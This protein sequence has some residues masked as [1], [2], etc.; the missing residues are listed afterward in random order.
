MKYETERF[1]RIV[2]KK[3][4][5]CKFMVKFCRGKKCGKFG[6][7]NCKCCSN[8]VYGCQKYIVECNLY[9]ILYFGICSIWSFFPKLGEKLQCFFKEQAIQDA[10]NLLFFEDIK[11]YTEDEYVKKVNKNYFNKESESVGKYQLDIANEIVYNAKVASY[12]YK[13][14]KVAVCIDVVAFIMFILNFIIA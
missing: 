13:M 11:K 3:F 9:I 8:I 6:T 2:R 5:K 12:K 7:G 1:E 14:F 10:D 4:C